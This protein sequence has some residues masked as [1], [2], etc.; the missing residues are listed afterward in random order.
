MSNKRKERVGTKERRTF[1]STRYWTKKEKK[2][3]S[4]WRFFRFFISYQH[5][6]MFYR[7]KYFDMLVS[8]YSGRKYFVR[9]TVAFLLKPER[10]VKRRKA[11]GKKSFPFFS[12]LFYQLHYAPKLVSFQLS[13]ISVRKTVQHRC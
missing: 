10:N 13:G 4:C 9:L 5:A 2:E 11:E 1:Y 8:V 7:R 6:S 3:S 12:M